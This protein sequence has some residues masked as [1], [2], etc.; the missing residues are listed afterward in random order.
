LYIDVA[1]AKIMAYGRLEHHRKL[2]HPNVT[3]LRGFVHSNDHLGVLLDFSDYGTLFDVLHTARWKKVRPLPLDLVIQ[4]AKDIALGLEY[5]SS[6][7]T[8]DSLLLP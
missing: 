4:F 5:L 2:N 6:I 1:E 3:A 8:W 7:G